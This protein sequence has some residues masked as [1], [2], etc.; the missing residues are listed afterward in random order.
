MS[1]KEAITSEQRAREVVAWL[2][3][4]GLDFAV[5]Q[6]TLE[7]LHCAFRN[8]AETEQK[9]CANI[10]QERALNHERRAAKCDRDGRHDLASAHNLE[11]QALRKVGRLHDTRC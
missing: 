2:K 3:A 1:T 5:E 4:R 7:V 10:V 8:T 11:S 9:A 6:D